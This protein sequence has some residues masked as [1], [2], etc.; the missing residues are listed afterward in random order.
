MRTFRRAAAR[1]TP[2]RSWRFIVTAG[3]PVHAVTI[4]GIR[5]AV[6]AKEWPERM[7]ESE[8]SGLLSLARDFVIRDGVT[9][10]KRDGYE[11]RIGD[12][13]VRRIIRA[14]AL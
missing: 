10:E 2:T 13:E 8:V 11:V 6:G 12:V 5:F 14:V 1:R 9:I 4:H 3:S 7:T